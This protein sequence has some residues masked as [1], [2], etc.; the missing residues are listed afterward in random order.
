[1]TQ[2][3]KAVSNNSGTGVLTITGND[4]IPV[5]PV[6]NNLDLIGIG[7]NYLFDAGAGTID[8]NNV[9]WITEYVVDASTVPGL[10]ASY[11]TIQSAITAATGAGGGTVA[12]RAGTYVENIVMA[13]DVNVIGFSGINPTPDTVISGTV[14]ASYTRTATITNMGI[15]ENVGSPIQIGGAGSMNLYMVNCVVNSVNT[16]IITQNN[17]SSG[18]ITLNCPMQQN[19]ANPHFVITAGQIISL[20]SFWGDNTGLSTPS[21]IVNGEFNQFGGLSSLGLELFNNSGANL[22]NVQANPSNGAAFTLH[23]TSNASALYSNLHAN[24]GVSP[25]VNL[26]DAGTSCG[27]SYVHMGASG[28]TPL[29]QG[30]GTFQYDHF[31]LGGSAT[32]ANAIAGTVTVVNEIV[33]P[34]STAVV[35]SGG[36]IP[37]HCYFNSAD[38]TVDN[39]GFVSSTGGSATI[40]IAGDTGSMT[41]SSLTLFAD[42]AA[43]NCGA[44]VEFVNGGV[45]STLNVTDSSNNTIIGLGSGSS[46][47]GGTD[48]VALGKGNLLNGLTTANGFCILGNNCLINNTSGFNHIAIGLGSL[49]NLTGGRGV[50]AIGTG[51]GSAYTSTESS[52]I[53]I[54]NAGVIGE[55]NTVRLGAQG[56]GNGQ[57]DTCFIAGI[58]GTSPTVNNPQVV[59]CNSQ[60]LMNVITANN[61]GFILTSNGLATAPTFQA[62]AASPFV[63]NYTTVNFAASPYT[64]LASDYYISV[65]SSA[66]PVS[67]VFPSPVLKQQW[68]VKDR[69]GS[70][71]TNNISLTAPGSNFDG[72]GTLVMSAN[73]EAVQLL[74]NTTAYEVF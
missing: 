27:C 41:G 55:S 64:V 19:G 31:G 30:L 58:T 9:Y 40:T 8:V 54:S 11:Q 63:P 46:A 61:A 33:L 18:L 20:D 65:D 14:T 4:G 71:A 5:S 51:S 29:V 72:A 60:G 56:S 24:D 59:T 13:P 23:D 21:Q 44:T 17:A 43:A 32:A 28:V 53:V 69:T 50:I 12:V 62:P 57:Q 37:G 68:I 10:N 52:N 47:F 22:Q 1:M 45:V 36:A 25:A 3:Y 16:P 39:T 66:G 70:A 73:F 48:C 6:A 74:A 49:H 42:Q 15:S 34:V 35:A 67:L 38:F 26:V 7:G 2:I